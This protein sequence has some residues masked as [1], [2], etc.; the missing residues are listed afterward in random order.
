MRPRLISTL[1][2]F[3]VPRAGPALLLACALFALPAS[4]RGVRFFEGSFEEAL[5]EAKAQKKNLVVEVYATWCGPCKQQNAEVFDTDDGLALTRNLVAWRID[6]DAESSRPLI[7]RW[8]ILS[9]PTVLFLRPDGSEIDRIEGYDDKAAFLK[10]AEARAQGFDPLPELE[11]KLASLEDKRTLRERL[12]V[13]VEVGHRSL[14]RGDVRRGLSL[15]D[16]AAVLD[17]DGRLGVAEDA[18]FLMGRYHSRVKRDFGTARNIWRE[19]YTRF[20][21][22]KYAT[23][24]AWWYAGAL[25]ELQEDALAVDVL[26]RRARG[27]A[28]DVEALDLLVSY[29]EAHGAGHAEAKE[30]LERAKGKVPEPARQELLARLQKAKKAR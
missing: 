21:E 7:E 8:A 15:L 29:A 3:S 22:G 17:A 27:R 23:T 5:A 19:L 10:L 13:M 16:G 4:A 9:L 20:P 14:V 30:R 25:H 12:S 24:A 18:L 11:K 26:E 1:I 28:K 2:A 6:Y